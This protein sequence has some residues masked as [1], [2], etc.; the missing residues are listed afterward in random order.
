MFKCIKTNGFCFLF[1]LLTLCDKHW[2]LWIFVVQL[3][4]IE[5]EFSVGLAEAR[6]PR[7]PRVVPK[8]VGAKVD[9]EHV[10]YVPV[11]IRCVM[12]SHYEIRVTIISINGV[13]PPRD[14]IDG[15][16]LPAN[17]RQQDGT[18]VGV[19]PP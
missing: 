11:N 15:G 17:R 2:H 13:G 18:H 6:L 7:W 5:D 4:S 10:R 19:H 9:D 8:V 1:G 14:D 16:V 12:A 3:G